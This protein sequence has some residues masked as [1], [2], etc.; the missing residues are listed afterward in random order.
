MKRKLTNAVAAELAHDG[1]RTLYVYDTEVRGFCLAVTSTGA[2]LFWASAGVATPSAI[3]TGAANILIV[4]RRS[5]V[6]LPRP[7]VA[8]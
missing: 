6:I 4:M 3:S 7:A 5:A 2:S 1:R 8:G